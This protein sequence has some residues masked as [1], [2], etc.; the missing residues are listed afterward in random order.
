MKLRWVWLILFAAIACQHS[1]NRYLDRIVAPDEVVSTWT[2]TPF[3]IESLKYAGH[4]KHLDTSEHSLVIRSDG[5]CRFQTFVRP[6]D[7]KG[8]DEGFVDAQCSWTLGDIDH[9]ALEIQLQS[10][11]T[12]TLGPYFYFDEENGNLVLWQLAGDPDAWKYMEFIK[13]HRG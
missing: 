3:G 5:T 8:V 1:E 7:T 9:Q 12:D 6:S 13:S 2:A 10:Q 4:T 11:P